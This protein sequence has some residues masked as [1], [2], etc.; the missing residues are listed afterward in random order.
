MFGY[1]RPEKWTFLGYPLNKIQFL[2]DYLVKCSSLT[3]PLAS[4]ELDLKVE[5]AQGI[6]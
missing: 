3:S 4:A 2:Q 1:N 5:L 6:G